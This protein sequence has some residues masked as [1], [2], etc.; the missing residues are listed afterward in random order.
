M[1]LVSIDKV[2]EEDLSDFD[3]MILGGLVYW[4]FE[5]GIVGE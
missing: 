1:P 5:S 3:K 4:L 2:S